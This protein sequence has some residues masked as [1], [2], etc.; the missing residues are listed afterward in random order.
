MLVLQRDALTIV[1]FTHD[2]VRGH[3]N[4]PKTFFHIAVCLLSRTKL[5]L[6][7][8][9][10]VLLC[11]FVLMISFHG[12]ISLL[13][14][15]GDDFACPRAFSVMIGTVVPS[16]QPPSSNQKTTRSSFLARKFV[17]PQTKPQHENANAI[18]GVDLCILHNIT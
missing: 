4:T 5:E 9:I 12:Y 15:R 14:A 1:G 6:G 16:P 2:D 7:I 10:L 3:K 13:E 17:A 18:N 8:L 11:F